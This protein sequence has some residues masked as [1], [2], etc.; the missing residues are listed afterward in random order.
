MDDPRAS[1]MDSSSSLTDNDEALV[2]RA[3]RDREAFECLYDRHV[4]Q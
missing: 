1:V 3:K 4:D 2:A